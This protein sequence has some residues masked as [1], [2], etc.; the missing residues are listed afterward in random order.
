MS[1]SSLEWSTVK[2]DIYGFAAKMWSHSL[3]SVWMHLT[4]R[5]R[6]YVPLWF[7]EANFL[8]SRKQFKVIVVVCLFMVFMI[9]MHLQSKETINVVTESTIEIPV[10]TVVQ[11]PII[12]KESWKKPTR[13]TVVALVF[14]GRREN[15]QILE[16]YL[17][18]STSFYC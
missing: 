11:T 17:R 3:R 15:V 8:S 9:T 14:Y 1:L 10:E 12:T 2:N 13:L 5:Y 7:K 4:N 18:V 6:D 16:R